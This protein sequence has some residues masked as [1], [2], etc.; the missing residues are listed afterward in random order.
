M[1]PTTLPCTRTPSALTSPLTMPASPTV[2]RTLLML[3]STVPS[4]WMSPSHEMSPLT[5]KSA[6]M[7]VGMPGLPKPFVCSRPPDLLL[8]NISSS[9]QEFG[10]IQVF[11]VAQHLVVYVRSR[12]AASGSH[13]P[14]HLVKR[15]LLP[16]L[17]LDPR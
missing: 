7:I 2:R 6:P 1:V 9:L 11:P 10:G 13:N 14:D 4:S 16:G 15:Y 8:R 17:N 12:A 5:R 3:P